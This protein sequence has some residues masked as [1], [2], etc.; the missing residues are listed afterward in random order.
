MRRIIIILITLASTATGLI[1][2]HLNASSG[3]KDSAGQLEARNVELPIEL[4]GHKFVLHTYLPSK[5]TFGSGPLVLYLS[6]AS[7]WHGFD[8]HIATTMALHGAAVYGLSLHSYLTTFYN[9]DHPV[10]VENL[11]EDYS[12]LIKEVRRVAGVGEATGI[13]LGGWSLGAGYAL[14]VAANPQIKPQVKGVVCIAISRENESFYSLLDALKS[15]LSLHTRGPFLDAAEALKRIAPL[16]VAILQA[17]SDKS[18]S[19]K[20]AQMLLQAAD[21]RVS[22]PIRLLIVKS[23][24]NHRFEGAR[25]DFDATLGQAL[26]WISATGGPR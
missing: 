21:L 25:N 13:V 2:F 15:K 19:P 18:A 24:R 3:D 22:D 14:I 8:D 6:G 26:D 1:F 7:G 9:G 4:R 20:E 5:Q 17:E 10:T 23:A 11:G 12:L 16:P